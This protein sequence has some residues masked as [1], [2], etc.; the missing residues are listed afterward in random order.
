MSDASPQSALVLS[1][2]RAQGFF[3]A[4]THDE[5]RSAT[6]RPLKR[7]QPRG[8]TRGDATKGKHLTPSFRYTAEQTIGKLQ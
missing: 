3:G 1:D 8:E 2:R 4:Q 7:V 5:V 6:G